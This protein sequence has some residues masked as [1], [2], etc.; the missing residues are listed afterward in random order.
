MIFHIPTALL[1]TVALIGKYTSGGNSGDRGPPSPALCFSPDLDQLR[2][3]D[4]HGHV[5]GAESHIKS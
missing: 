4:G 2:L 1:A 5:Q 3:S